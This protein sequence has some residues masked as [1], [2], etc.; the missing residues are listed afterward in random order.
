M[1]V[2][3]SLAGLAAAAVTGSVL[4]LT[5]APATAAVDPDDTTFAPVAADLVGVGSDTSQHALKLLADGWNATSPAAKLATYAATGGGDVTLHTGALRRPNGSGA[6]K[7]LLYGAGNNAGV[8]F[9]RSSSGPSTA[10][11]QAGL[12]NFPFAL[13]TLVMAV[14]GSTASNAPA[15]LTKDQIV[16]IYDGTVT[17][18]SQVGGKDGVIKP[19]IPQAGSGTRSFF[20]AQLQAAN[21]GVAVTLAKSVAEVQEHDDTAIK[22][23][24]NAVAPFSEGRAGLLGKTLRLETGFRADRAL[25]NVV[26]GADLATAAV[27]SVFGEKGYLCSSDARAL[28][29]RAG[30]KQLATPAQGGVCGQ[31]TQSATSNFTLNESVRTTLALSGSSTRAKSATLVA[32]VTGSTAP[33]G[34]VTFTSGGTTLAT[35]VPLVSGRA[36]YTATGLDLGSRSFAAEF[37]PAQGSAFEGSTAT[38]SVVVKAGSAVS[39]TFPA[40]VAK[41]KKAA[42]TVTVALTGASGQAT[43]T[44]K[45]MEGS[46]TLKSVAL[47]GGKATVKLPKLAKGKHSLKAVWGGNGVAVGATKSFT[48]TQK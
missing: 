6:G 27:Q 29:E 15:A 16:D 44:V 13:D 4:A 48:I 18:W 34:T 23:D 45:V 32:Q 7:A 21:G 9:A 25:Y 39:E 11:V 41:G 31:A 2:R 3:K 36:T 10:E 33:Q 28:I 5:A 42:G 20:T 35:G 46:K 38:A 30:F 43:G 8:D 37:V 19:L 26:R 24:P 1:S 12:Q 17:N 22:G 47:K 40:K 14:S